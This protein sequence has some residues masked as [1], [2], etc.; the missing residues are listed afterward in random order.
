MR[1]YVFLQ[2]FLV[3]F[4][5]TGEK[6]VAAVMTPKNETVSRRQKPKKVDN[7]YF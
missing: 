4:A 3:S 7:G 2:A 6:T 1:F 5:T